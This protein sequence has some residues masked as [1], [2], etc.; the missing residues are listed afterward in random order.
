MSHGDF[1]SISIVVSNETMLNAFSS[2]ILIE[3]HNQ[4]DNAGTKKQGKS[5]DDMR[6][7]KSKRKKI[8]IFF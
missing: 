2:D 8:D 5:R 3:R 6:K 7:T 1:L 4:K